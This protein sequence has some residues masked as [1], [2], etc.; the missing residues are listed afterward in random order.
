VI[1]F[2]E[3]MDGTS[4]D[5]F[6]Q[7]STLSKGLNIVPGANA[8][9]RLDDYW[10]NANLIPDTQLMKFVTIPSAIFVTLG[11]LTDRLID[12]VRIY[13]LPNQFSH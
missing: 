3:E 13:T 9:A 10:P 1:G 5:L 12:A 4:R 6:K 2:N 8:V 7:G 11:A